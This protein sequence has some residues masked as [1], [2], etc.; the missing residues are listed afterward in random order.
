MVCQVLETSV[1]NDSPSMEESPNHVQK[2]SSNPVQKE[3]STPFQDDESIEAIR[4]S[5]SPL[6]D[7]EK[8]EVLAV[9]IKNLK[10]SVYYGISIKY[11]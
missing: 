6:K 11:A 3:S 5:S 8:I 4:D 1:Q 10:V 2:E 7:T 9:E